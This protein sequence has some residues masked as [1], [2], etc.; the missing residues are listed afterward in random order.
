MEDWRRPATGGREDPVGVLDALTPYQLTLKGLLFPWRFQLGL[1]AFAGL[2]LA[3]IGL[4]MLA[5]GWTLVSCVADVRLQHLYGRWFE[6]SA[7]MDSARGLHR[8]SWCL[9][10]RSSLWL[11][12]PM[13]LVLIT[14]APAAYAYSALTSLSMVALAVSCGWISR[15]VCAG[16]AAPAVLAIAIEALPLLGPIHAIGVTMGIASFVT[17]GVLIAVGTEKS[18]SEW[19]RANERTRSVMARLKEALVRS[20]AAERRLRVGAEIAKLH[21]FEADFV[22]KTLASQGAEAD[23]Y[24]RPLTFEQFAADPFS[25]VAAE[26]RERVVAA[27]EA[28]QAG[29]AP[30][31]VQFRVNRS[32][33]EVWA[34]AIGELT[35]SEDGQPATLV[36]A[37]HN[38]TDVKQSELELIAGRDRAEAGNR[39]KSEFLATIS[40]EIRTPLNGVLGMAQVM[41]RDDLTP[42]QRSRL[43]VIRNS[44]ERLLALLNSLLDLSKIEAGKLELEDGEIDVAAVAQ[45]VFDAFG[46]EVA[47]TD[48]SFTLAVDPTA[49]GVYV[50]DALRLGQILQNLVSNA[51][52]FTERGSIDIT[53]GGA[54][55]GLVLQVADTGIG[56]APE[57]QAALF[58]KFVQAD[59]SITRRY[60]GSGLGL[61]ICQQLAGMMGG[62]VSLESA[63]GRGSTFTVALKL[64]RLRDAAPQHSAEALAPDPPSEALRALRILV[65]DDNAANRLVAQTLLQQI[66]VEATVVEDGQQ[67]VRA[68]EFGEWDL[69]LMDIQMP[70]MDGVTATR[71]VRQGEAQ[72]GRR[73]TPIIAITANVMA[74]QLDEYRSAGMD[75][76]VAKP[77]H[78]TA[79]LAAMET[80]LA[81]GETGPACSRFERPF[82]NSAR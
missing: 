38:I 66:G 6:T 31:R 24:D 28:Y 56:I 19:S 60:G 32:D 23:F 12:A 79:L 68:W 9:A 50:G 5:L 54:D 70:I 82:E 64:R 71:R 13:A 48:V 49:Q 15:G 33:R 37:L 59:S 16:I 74:R 52:K 41:E 42:T 40:H 22:G 65:V 62:S 36:C 8:L 14:H 3:L 10:L 27:W 21:L 39:A 44:G 26:D 73:R 63:P 72:A 7:A 17:T 80:A 1:N 53:I 76:I 75:D 58:E 61:A 57:Q 30:Y 69:I 78:A 46:G 34:S 43:E 29:L 4:P 67:A 35:Y 77:I 55:G 2:S 45:S 25:I 18:L 11:S 20:E 51:V 81:Q 47:D